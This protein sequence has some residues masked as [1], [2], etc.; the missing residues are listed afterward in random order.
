M[1][2][3]L[4]VMIFCVSALAPDNGLVIADFVRNAEAKPMVPE[5]G[6]IQVRDEASTL[7][8]IAFD[9]RA[10]DVGGSQ[11]LCIAQQSFQER[12]AAPQ[13]NTEKG[14]R[15]GRRPAR[16]E[17]GPAD[18]GDACWSRQFCFRENNSLK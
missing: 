10:H 14:M 1:S 12:S 6:Q 2:Q 7:L 5:D 17:R 8:G 3:A 15:E 11:R 13:P 18:F 9:V 16:S 4:F